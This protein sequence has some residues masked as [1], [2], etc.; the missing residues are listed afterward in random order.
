[1]RANVARYLF[2]LVLVSAAQMAYAQSKVV[3]VPLG[4]D[5]SKKGG[6]VSISIPVTS[7]VQS[8]GDILDFTTQVQ[9]RLYASGLT[10]FGTTF[11]VPVDHKPGTLIYVDIYIYNRA[12]NGACQAVIR[13]NYGRAWK[14]GE[15]FNQTGVFGFAQAFPAFTQG[16]QTYVQTYRFGEEIGAGHSVGFGMFRSGDNAADNCGEVNLVG[17]QIRYERE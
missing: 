11:L 2:L 14:P 4:G 3:V 12:M 17:M 16:D 6:E 8:N 1:M 10:S 5:E 13:R 7:L 9:G 15:P